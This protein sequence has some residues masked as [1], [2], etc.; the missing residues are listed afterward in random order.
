MAR[1]RVRIFLKTLGSLQASCLELRVAD[2]KLFRN[3]QNRILDI[4]RI[5]IKRDRWI[6]EDQFYKYKDKQEAF[7]NTVSTIA[8]G[9]A[10]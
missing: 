4:R 7:K 5:T 3:I 9:K 10:R 8:L 2:Q 1:F 6:I